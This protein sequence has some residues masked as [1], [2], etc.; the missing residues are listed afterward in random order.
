VLR[1]NPAK[2]RFLAVQSVAEAPRS[3][4]EINNMK[5]HARLP[6]PLLLPQTDGV[7]V[8]TE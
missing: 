1:L 6:K 4:L 5:T 7:T 3:I 8:Q 2:C